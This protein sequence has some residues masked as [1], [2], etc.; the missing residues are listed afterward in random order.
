MA[1]INKG[2]APEVDANLKKQIDGLKQVTTEL[3]ASMRSPAVGIIEIDGKPAT[4]VKYERG[5]KDGQP[6]YNV[7]FTMDNKTVAKLKGLDD[8]DLENAVGEKNAKAIREAEAEKGTPDGDYLFRATFNGESRTQE[9]RL[10]DGK[11]E[12]TFSDPEVT[13]AQGD[14]NCSSWRRK[15]TAPFTAVMPSVLRASNSSNARNSSM[16]VC[17]LASGIK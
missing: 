11:A 5:E 3:N 7:S 13:M 1:E 2:N 10:S 17:S 8:I 9:A 12:A 14:C 15:S 4:A 16:M 6:A